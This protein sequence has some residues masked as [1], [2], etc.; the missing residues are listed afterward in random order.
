MHATL[1]S[2][3]DTGQVRATPAASTERS[4]GRGAMGVLVD[5]HGRHITDLRVSV[6]D[7]CNLRCS[8]CVPAEGLVF[9]KRER[10]LHIEEIARLVEVAVS[11]GINKFRLTGG[12]PL[13]R[14]EL[15][16]LV[17]RLTQLP[18]V[19]DVPLTTNGVLLAEQA[20]ALYAAGARRLNV[21]LDALNQE[22]YQSLTRCDA[23]PKV[24]A[25]ISAAR[26]AGFRIK[27]NM[28]PIRGVNE[29]QILPMAHWALGKGFHLRFIEYMPFVSNGW[30]REQV[31]T[32][33]EL[34]GILAREL[35]LGEGQRTQPDSPAVD[36]P[37]A[38]AN[39]PVGV[40]ACVTE[41]FCRHCSRMRLT[42]EGALRPCLHS[43]VELDVAE[44]LRAGASDNE[45]RA[46]FR[47]AAA[48]KPS[49][50]QEF[51]ASTLVQGGVAARPMIRIGG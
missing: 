5:A 14:R 9:A 46:L 17:E 33:A 36:Y 13:V 28:I 20:S 32:A 11:L 38:G 30:S 41:P 2:L 49:G 27:I 51:H 40:I 24:L 31:I 25:G 19:E 1:H 39:V 50:R 43:H 16:A 29:D 3:D 34:R 35:N 44:R 23:L 12:E 10:L 48:A 42:A 21:S 7:R 22:C 26:N 6:T 15:P 18:G 4:A 8:Y 47:A 45:L 37:V